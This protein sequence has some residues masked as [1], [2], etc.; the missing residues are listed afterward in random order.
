[1]EQ[2]D[3]ADVRDRQLVKLKRRVVRYVAGHPGC[4]TRRWAIT[5]PA[6]RGRGAGRSRPRSDGTLEDRAP[7]PG[8]PTRGGTGPVTWTTGCRCPAGAPAVP[9]RGTQLFQKRRQ[10]TGAPGK[11]YGVSD[12]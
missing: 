5:S 8:T 3:A 2:D 11:P 10:F 7:T 12:A 4:A 1:M 6:A 9:A